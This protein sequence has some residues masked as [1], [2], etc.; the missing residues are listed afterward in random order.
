MLYKSNFM[1]FLFRFSLVTTYFG[2]FS[3]DQFYFIFP[4]ISFIFVIISYYFL[5]FN[6]KD[7][8]TWV[9]HLNYGI[10]L[11]F[12]DVNIETKCNLD[13]KLQQRFQYK[14][15][16]SFS[17]FMRNVMFRC[18]PSHI[19]FLRFWLYLSSYCLYF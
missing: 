12:T 7:L 3:N 8:Q 14:Y 19:S 13:W 15:F 2:S 17:H 4:Y 11:T 16:T 5:C 18:P 1:F 9:V 6:L 10:L